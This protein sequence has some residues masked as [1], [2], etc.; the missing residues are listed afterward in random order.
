MS[1]FTLQVS[2][3][4]QNI[5]QAGATATYQVQLTPHPLFNSAISLS[6]TGF[7]S[8]S[9]CNFSPGSSITLQ[10][11]SGSTATL[12]IPTQARPVTPTTGSMWKRQ[13]Y[14]LWLIV[15]GWALIGFG[16]ERRRKKIAGL[17]FLCI[18]LGSLFFLPSCSHSTTQTP[19]AGTQAGTY[20]ITVTASSGTDSK[21]QTITLNVP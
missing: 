7:P 16:G 9:A 11:A 15:P 2:P 20:T 1:D 10:G 21:S 12:S 3:A 14:A 19:P 18:V 8:G 13:F 5:P 6:C 4:N 17:F